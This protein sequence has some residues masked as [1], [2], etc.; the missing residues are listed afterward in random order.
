MATVNPSPSG[1][2]GIMVLNPCGEFLKINSEVR[3]NLLIISLF[4][5]GRNGVY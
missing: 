3:G 4:S 2:E 1:C 5:V